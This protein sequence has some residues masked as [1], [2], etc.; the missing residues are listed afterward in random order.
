MSKKKSVSGFTLLEVM[1]VVAII[2]VMAGIAVPSFI[3]WI[4]DYRIRSATRDIVSAL[5]EM[6]MRAVAE[7]SNTVIIFDLSKHSYETFVDD[8]GAAGTG[9]ADDYVH[10]GS[11]VILRDI[12]LPLGV[13]FVSSTFNSSTAPYS[14]GFNSRGL[15]SK[16]ATGGTITL[17]NS[18]SKTMAVIV[19]SVGNIRVP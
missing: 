13:E 9:T 18:N 6:K 15:P 7:N 5:Q 12:A 3:G 8:G 11:E 4:P 1:I 16:G 19:N 10:N 17:Q 2:G 14:F